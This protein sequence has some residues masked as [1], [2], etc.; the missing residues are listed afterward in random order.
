MPIHMQGRCVCNRLQYTL[1][2]PSPDAARTTLCHCQSCRR[3]FGANYGLTAKVPCEAFRYEPG[4]SN[5]KRY[6]QENGVTREFCGECGVFVCEYGEEAADKFRYVVWG[7]LDE[8]EM[9]PPKGEFFCKNRTEWMPELQGVFH[10]KEIK[11]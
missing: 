5:L 2:L 1:D 4:S 11:E 9:V 8:P 3:A 10:K 7:S 6:R